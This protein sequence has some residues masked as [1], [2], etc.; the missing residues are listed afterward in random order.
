MSVVLL[1]TRYCL[2]AISIR[3]CMMIDIIHLGMFMIVSFIICLKI[4]TLMIDCE[5]SNA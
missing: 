4:V 2:L 1:F 5:V 3:S